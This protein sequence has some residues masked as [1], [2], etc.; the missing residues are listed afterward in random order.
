M[1][2]AHAILIILITKLSSNLIHM[3][4]VIWKEGDWIVLRDFGVSK[5]FT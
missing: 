3:I 5:L 1:V 2:I 4:A